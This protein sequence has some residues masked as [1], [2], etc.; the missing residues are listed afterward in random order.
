MLLSVTGVIALGKA[1]QHRQNDPKL[2]FKNKLFKFVFYTC[3]TGDK[4]ITQVTVKPSQ[5]AMS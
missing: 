1:G 3:E 5:F 2:Y 4:C